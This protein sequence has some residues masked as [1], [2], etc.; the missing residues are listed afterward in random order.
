MKP[1]RLMFCV[2]IV[3][4]TLLAACVPA[5]TPTPVIIVPAAT[6][7]PGTATSVPPAATSTTAPVDLAGPPM[8]VGS[9]YLYFDGALLVAV[10]GGPFTMGHGG[11]DNPEHTVTL[12]DF[13]IYSTKITNREFQQCVAV[14]KC[15]SPDPS[16]N[17]AYNDPARQSDPVVGVNWAQSEAYC[18]YAN[19]HLPT[20]AQ[21]EKAAR[22]PN[23]NIYPWGNNAPGADLL[24][25]NNN[26]GRTT[27]VIN[28]PKGKSYYDAL[29]LEGNA[30][31]WVYD[32]YDPLYYKTSPAQ[33]PLGPDAGVGGQ[34]SVRSA[35]YKSDNDQVA[36]STRF[37]KLSTDHARDLGFRCVVKNPTFFAPFCQAMVVYGMNASGSSSSGGS[38]NKCPDPSIIHTEDCG[39]GNTQVNNIHLQAKSPTQINSVSGGGSCNPPLTDPSDTAGHQCPL[40]I[41]ITITATCNI[42]ASTADAVS[43][44]SG[45]TMSGDDTTC[46]AQGEPGQCPTGSAY[47]SAHMCCTALPGGSASQ[48][49]AGFH[50]YQGAC[51][52]DSSGLYNPNPQSYTTTSGLQCGGSHSGNPGGNNNN[53]CPNGGT[54]TCVYLS[55]GRPYCYCK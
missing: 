27:S 17:Q 11:S 26:I 10:P 6:A 44:P 20:E 48:C 22:G 35:G 8:Q 2:S 32:W 28:Y 4:M 7:V 33:D 52:P 39:I 29:D 42:S 25:Y 15:T 50:E 9:T 40:G 19:G 45:F 36:S 13:W 18:E 38:N 24:N 1:M 12:S 21:W 3:L 46:N 41:T 54:Y 49:S 53:Q 47:D 55:A 16:D 30:Y 43:C 37:F 5:S 31:E 51:V 14:A 34:R 23:G